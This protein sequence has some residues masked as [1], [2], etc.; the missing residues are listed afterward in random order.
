M[1]RGRRSKTGVCGE[2]GAGRINFANESGRIFSGWSH[3][4]AMI[5]TKYTGAGGLKTGSVKDA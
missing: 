2:L 4:S 1:G 5:R 3:R